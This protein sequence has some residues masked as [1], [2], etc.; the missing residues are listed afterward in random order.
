MFVDRTKHTL[1]KKKETESLKR[2]IIATSII[3]NVLLFHIYSKNITSIIDIT[4]PV[5]CR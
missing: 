2:S 4:T 1:E 5:F 3:N